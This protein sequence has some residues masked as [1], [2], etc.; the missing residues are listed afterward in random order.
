MLPLGIL[1]VRKFLCFLLWSTIVFVTLVI[2]FY[3][4]EDLRGARA[5]AKEKSA[6]EAVGETLDAS[7]FVPPPIPDAQ[8]FGSLPLYQLT[9]NPE[10]NYPSPYPVALRKAFDRVVTYEWLT[11]ESTKRAGSFPYLGKWQEGERPDLPAIQSKLSQL[12]REKLPSIKIPSDLKSTELYDLLCPALGDLRAANG[13][14]PLCR[15]ARGEEI[16]NSWNVS[17]L[18]ARGLMDL[19]PVLS[20]QERLA[21]LDNQPGIA[22]ADMQVGWKI[23]SGLLE[24]EVREITAEQ[25]DGINEGLERHSWNDQ[26]LVVLDDD[27]GKIDL[28]SLYRLEVRGQFACSIIPALDHFRADRYWLWDRRGTYEP[29][30]GY[31]LFFQF[32]PNGWVDELKATYTKYFLFEAIHTVDSASHRVFPNKEENPPSS[33]PGSD[34]RGLGPPYD[35]WPEE[36]TWSLYHRHGDFMQ[37]AYTQVQIDQARIACWLERYY[38]AHDEYPAALDSLVPSY[39]SD[40]PHDIMNGEPFHYKLMG[41]GKYRLYSVGWNLKDDKG[42]TGMYRN[43]QSPDWV[44]ANYPDLES[45]K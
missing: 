7:R 2:L 18:L 1:A 43:L 44:W 24:S 22:L 13:S 15:F 3:V 20:Y 36:L 12:Y 16:Q 45:T 10:P 41:N 34:P 25:L 28:L 29:P 37:M 39:G 9:T 8:N 19:G 38:L 17:F 32:V 4:E 23:A 5:W 35:M 33:S 11:R 14:H 21:L 27:L 30:W 6:L 31:R 40:L 26:Q 42:E